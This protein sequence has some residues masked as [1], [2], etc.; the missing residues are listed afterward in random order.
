MLVNPALKDIT[1]REYDVLDVPTAI[2]APIHRP[3]LAPREQW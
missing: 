2:T 1:V 3:L